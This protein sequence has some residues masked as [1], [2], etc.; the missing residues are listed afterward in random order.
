MV[1]Y[2]LLRLFITTRLGLHLLLR[3]LWSSANKDSSNFL[4]ACLCY[5]SIPA[6]RTQRHQL[7]L[8]D[9]TGWI[10]RLGKRQELLDAFMVEP[11]QTGLIVL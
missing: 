11:R 2:F 9:M 4:A 3:Q 5:T 7:Q 10:P 6:H 8:E 1:L